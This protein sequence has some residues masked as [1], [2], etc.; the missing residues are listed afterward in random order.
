LIFGL[1]IDSKKPISYYLDCFPIYF[2]TPLFYEQIIELDIVYTVQGQEEQVKKIKATKSLTVMNLFRIIYQ[3]IPEL[4]IYLFKLKSGE[5][6]LNQNKLISDYEN[7][8]N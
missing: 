1:L 4:E 6:E 8:E 3:F 5:T 2:K 7:I